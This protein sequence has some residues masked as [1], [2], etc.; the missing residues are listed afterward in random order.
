ML[1]DFNAFLADGD[2]A[3][4]TIG[5]ALGRPWPVPLPT[6]MIGEEPFLDPALIRSARATGGSEPL[7]I[8]VEE[9][10]AAWRCGLAGEGDRMRAEFDR[11]ADH[12]AG[13]GIAV[14][15]VAVGSG[16]GR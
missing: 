2:S 6:A 16:G 9:A 12:H 7:P 8:W 5:K 1:V 10:D 3:L 15:A 14:C 13:S 11:L 4:A